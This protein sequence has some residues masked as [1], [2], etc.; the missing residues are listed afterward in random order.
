M[1]MQNPSTLARQFVEDGRSADCPI[2][3]MHGH[4][5]TYYCGYLPAPIRS[6]CWAQSG[7]PATNG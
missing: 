7:A 4:Y 6:D 3:D 2:L 1:R 5:S